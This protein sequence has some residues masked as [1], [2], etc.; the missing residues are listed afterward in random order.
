MVVRRHSCPSQPSWAFELGYTQL[1]G[2]DSSHSLCGG[3]TS[4]SHSLSACLF[5]AQGATQDF[6]K[7]RRASHHARQRNQP[8]DRI[9]DLECELYRIKDTQQ[10]RTFQKQC[11]QEEVEKYKELYLKEV[12]ISKCLAKKLERQVHFLVAIK[13]TLFPQASSFQIALLHLSVSRV[14]AWDT[15]ILVQDPSP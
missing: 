9:G 13:A 6:L 15:I 10:D 8:E 4:L 11:V 2:G 14:E 12:E 7:Q 5:Q 3:W 1:S